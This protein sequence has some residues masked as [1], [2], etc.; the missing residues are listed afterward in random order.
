[1][2]IA[3]AA[4][5]ASTAT[6]LLDGRFGGHGK[7]LGVAL[8]AAGLALGLATL[9]AFAFTRPGRPRGQD[10]RGAPGHRRGAAKSQPPGREQAP[11]GA[12]PRDSRQP[13]RD[14]GAGAAIRW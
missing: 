8:A 11:G 14:G 2:I 13:A 5:V 1:M 3:G 6:H 9:L 4:A 10:R 7:S 12:P